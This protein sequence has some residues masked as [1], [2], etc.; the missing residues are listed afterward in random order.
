MGEV[1]SLFAACARGQ[2]RCG[3]SRLDHRWAGHEV[4]I[5]SSLRR[6]AIRQREPNQ[7]TDLV[8]SEAGDNGR[9]PCKRPKI[10]ILQHH[11]RNDCEQQSRDQEGGPLEI[12][13][14]NKAHE[15]TSCQQNQNDGK[16]R[17]HSPPS[18]LGRFPCSC[19]GFVAPTN[20]SRQ[21]GGRIGRPSVCPPGCPVPNEASFS[22][23]E[24]RPRLGRLSGV[25][26]CLAQ[27]GQPKSP[28]RNS[29]C[30]RR[31]HWF[32]PPTAMA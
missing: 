1:V 3:N 16:R 12:A 8:D 15:C 30:T 29:R 13:A 26:D 24:G 20:H 27:A 19:P 11:R 4:A 21:H 22:N 7:K 23:L 25:P 28:R 9:D 32:L 10:R 17:E 14:Q 5:F 31:L 2:R 6:I 18:P